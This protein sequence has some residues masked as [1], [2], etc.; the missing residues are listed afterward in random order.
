MPEPACPV[1]LNVDDTEA[2]R[3][4]IS[5][6]LESA[7]FTVWQAASGQEA[8][9][10][11]AKGPDLVIL[12]V[13]LPDISGFEVCRRMKENPQTAHIPVLHQSAT[14]VGSHAKITGLEGGADAYLIH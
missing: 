5:R 3:Y 1:I 9:E 11:V 12:D 6:T 14:Y 4:A 13:K 2:Q 7:G 8:L 10:Q